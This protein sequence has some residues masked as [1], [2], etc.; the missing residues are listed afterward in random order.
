MIRRDAGAHYNLGCMYALGEGVEMD[1]EKK[2]YHY[3]K[4]A[5]GGHPK[6]RY[7]LACIEC[8]KGNM[9][10]AAKHFIIAA[11]LGDENSMK[12]LW[13]EFKGGNITKEELEATLRSHQVA[14]DAMK[15]PEREK[16]EEAIKNGCPIAAIKL[17]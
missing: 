2:V 10:R 1:E 8:K 13:E 12:E 7:N 14:L 11:N 3:E 9:E 4:A 17:I 5:I 16:V 6:A 15:S